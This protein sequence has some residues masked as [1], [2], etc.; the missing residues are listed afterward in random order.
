[1][2]LII[3]TFGALTEQASRKVQKQAREAKVIAQRQALPEDENRRVPPILPGTSTRE[4]L[5]ECVR[6]R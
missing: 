4:V 6:S 5:T 3:R 1:M 2:H